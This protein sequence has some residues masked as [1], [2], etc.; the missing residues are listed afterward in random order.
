MTWDPNGSEVQNTLLLGRDFRS[1]G[2]CDYQFF[3]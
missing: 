3:K 1:S 2:M